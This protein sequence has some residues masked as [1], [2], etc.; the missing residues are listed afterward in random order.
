M[1]ELENRPLLIYDGE[2]EFCVK[3]ARKFKA[4]AGKFITFIPL[5]NLPV[6]YE[7][8][9]RAACLKS[10]QYIDGNN[11][12]SKGAEAIFQLFHT[13]KKSSFLFTFYRRIP[14]F[15]VFTEFIYSWIARNRHLFP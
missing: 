13:A 8:V 12:V 7:Y 3:W 9:S 6:D 15:R 4:M 11:R 2:C 10:V 14:I 5:Q 1:N